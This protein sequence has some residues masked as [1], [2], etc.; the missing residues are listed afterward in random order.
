MP[1]TKLLLYYDTPKVTDMVV[2]FPGSLYVSGSFSQYI[3]I[4]LCKELLN[5]QKY[6]LKLFCRLGNVN[7][8]G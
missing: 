2:Q 7:F 6:T 3:P 1:Q 8:H 5:G 4:N